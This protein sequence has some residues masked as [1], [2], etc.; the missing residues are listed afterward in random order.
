MSTYK[1]ATTVT[2]ANGASVSSAADLGDT[3]LCG[4]ISPAA[5]TAAAITFEA[6][7]DGVTWFPMRTTAGEVTI[8]TGQISATEARY[9]AVNP[10]DFR[11]VEWVRIRS[12]VSGSFVNQGAARTLTLVSVRPELA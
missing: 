10:A 11:G 7:L 8:A 1:L 9:L 12:G 6:S 3:V 2:I 5:W 4:V